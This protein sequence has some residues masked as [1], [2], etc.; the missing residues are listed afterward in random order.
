VQGGSS[1]LLVITTGMSPTTRVLI[2]NGYGAAVTNTS[3]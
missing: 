2:T 1:G 3:Y